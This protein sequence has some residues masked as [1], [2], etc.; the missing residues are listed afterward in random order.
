[1]DPWCALMQAYAVLPQALEAG[2]PDALFQLQGTVSVIQMGMPTLLNSLLC[3]V[4][5]GLI[6]QKRFEEA[7]AALAQAEEINHSQNSYT[8][9]PEIHCLRGDLFQASGQLQQSQ[10][11]WNLARASALRHGLLPYVAWV[12]ARFDEQ[13]AAHVA[14]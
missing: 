2:N 8:V 11:A 3:L 4:A 7:A 14:G 5:R 6:A 10:A 1:T 12:D 9:E 13:R